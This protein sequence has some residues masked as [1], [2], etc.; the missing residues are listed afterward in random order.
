MLVLHGGFCGASLKQTRDSVILSVRYFYTFESA[1][2]LVL[3]S[4]LLNG[5]LPFLVRGLLSWTVFSVNR[6]P[7]RHHD[8]LDGLIQIEQLMILANVHQNDAERSL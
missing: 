1:A 6:L 7:T 4:D 2:A 8:P 3:Y 5:C